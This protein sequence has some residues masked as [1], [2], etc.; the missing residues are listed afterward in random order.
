MESSPPK[1]KLQSVMPHF[2]GIPNS[3]SAN[4]ISPD[5]S[6]RISKVNYFLYFLSIFSPNNFIHYFDIVKK[7]EQ[8][9]KKTT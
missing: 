9:G 6:A 3:E 4:A 1:N 7:K 8:Q 2:M 5:I